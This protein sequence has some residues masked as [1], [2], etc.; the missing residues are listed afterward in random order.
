MFNLVS[1]LVVSRMIVIF[2]EVPVIPV[3]TGVT[4]GLYDSSR[5]YATLHHLS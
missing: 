5:G 4:S 1:V 3:Y 2:V